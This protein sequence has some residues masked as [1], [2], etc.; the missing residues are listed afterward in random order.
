M[1]KRL[2]LMVLLWFFGGMCFVWGFL[3]C[4]F[5]FGLVFSPLLES[6]MK[7]CEIIVL[8]FGG[9]GGECGGT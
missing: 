4:G 5:G 7:K 8:I 6:W 2:S 1:L 3:C 9:G